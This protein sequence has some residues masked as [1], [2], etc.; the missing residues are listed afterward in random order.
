MLYIVLCDLKASALIKNILMNKTLY[1]FSFFFSV[2]DEYLRKQGFS[3]KVGTFHGF[4]FFSILNG[5]EIVLHAGIL[6]PLRLLGFLKK[7]F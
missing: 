6:E 3:V 5:R 2:M 1:F 7:N 4:S